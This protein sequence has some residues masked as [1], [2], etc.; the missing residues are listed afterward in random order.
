MGFLLAK[1]T[2]GDSLNSLAMTGDYP[3]S[4][5]GGLAKPELYAGADT[6]SAE[7][8]KNGCTVTAPDA[9]LHDY[10]LRSS[11]RHLGQAPG[12]LHSKRNSAKS[13]RAT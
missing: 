13:N 2:F 5:T 6:P 4:G 7:L 8:V 12:R 1:V 11:T 9:E 3:V 10:T